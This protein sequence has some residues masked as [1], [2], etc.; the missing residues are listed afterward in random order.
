[1]QILDS[2]GK[3]I[4][5]LKGIP[6]EKGM[7]RISWDLSYE[8]SAPRRPPTSPDAPIFGPRGPQALPGKY[9]A[10]LLVG[11]KSY[12]QLVEVKMD[13]TVSISAADLQTQFD[14]A[15]K[16]RDLQSVAN[17]GLRSLDSLKEQLQTIEKT[18]KDRM[19]DAPKEL[20]TAISDNSKQA[21][22]LLDEMTAPQDTLGITGRTK[23]AD[24]I[25]G[26][27]FTV[28][29]ADAAPTPAMKEAFDELQSKFRPEMEKINKFI[30]QSIPQLN[31]ALKKN[32]APVV[33][34]GKAVDLK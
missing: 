1:M 11:D 21:Q 24:Q 7:N 19:P 27:F 18:I 32:N 28:D 23:L 6:K 8:G 30:T 25:G 12:E 3:V 17:N 15:M 22:T 31:E 13:P 5:E 26:L 2:S 20:M 10:K 29:G 4:K 9:T 33:I 34:A 14:Y 16:L